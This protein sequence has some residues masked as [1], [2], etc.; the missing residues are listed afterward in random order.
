MSTTADLVSAEMEARVNEARNAI[1]AGDIV[2]H[3]YMADN[4]CPI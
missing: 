1:I 3:D 4:T 2:V